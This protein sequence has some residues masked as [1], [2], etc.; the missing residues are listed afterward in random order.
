MLRWHGD[1]IVSRIEKQSASITGCIARTIAEKARRLCP[2]KTGAL[3]KSIKAT[4]DG[5]EVT[6]DYAGAVEF[7][8][9][10]RAAKPFMRPAIEQLKKSDID[11]C[12]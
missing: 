4:D 10:T 3:Q 1:K 6:E 8:T 9:A 5:V 2:V 12:I 7:G 11:K